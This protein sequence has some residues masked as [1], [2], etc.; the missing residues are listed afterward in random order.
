MLVVVAKVWVVVTLE[1]V[2][3][4]VVVLVTVNTD[5]TGSEIAWNV[6]AYDSPEALSMFAAISSSSVVAL[7]DWMIP[8][9]SA[10]DVPSLTGSSDASETS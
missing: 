9:M 2:V 4:V 3:V 6:N 7:A 10:L 8:M 5:V 1:L